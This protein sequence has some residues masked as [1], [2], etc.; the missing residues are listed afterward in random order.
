MSDLSTPMILAPPLILATAAGYALA[1]VGMKSAS[2]GHMTLGLAIAIIGFGLACIAEIILMK[3]I[4]VS[5]IYIAV[6][7]AE[8]V[9]VLTY[10][11]WIGETLSLRQFVGAGMVLA[12]LMAVTA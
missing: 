5:I 10:A 12:G 11:H 9:L 7:A 1:T 3:R 2:S 6:V 4:D 8:T